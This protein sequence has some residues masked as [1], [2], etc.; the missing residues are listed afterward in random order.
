M[1]YRSLTYT[2]RELAERACCSLVGDGNIHISDLTSLDHP[3]AGAVTFIKTDSEDVVAKHLSTLRAPAA[4]IL[5][6]KVAPSSAPEGIAV[7]VAEDSFATFVG[8]VPLFYQEVSYPAG[9]HPTAVIDPSAHVDPSAS[10]GAYCVVGARS[11]IG[12]NVSLLPH[13]RVYED[14]TIHD[15]ARLYSG[16][17]I[18]SG[19]S[20][21]ARTVIHDNAV[22]GADGFGYL[23]DATCGLKKVPQVGHVEISSDVEIG[24][25]TCIDRGAYGPTR[26][27]RGVKID[28][29]VQ[30]GHNVT[31]GDF[32]VVCGHAA[33]GG[34]TKIG[35]GV[36]IGGCTGLADHLEIVSGVRVGGGSAV[37]NSL[38]EPGDYIG[39]PAVKAAQW[40]RIQVKLRREISGGQKN[41]K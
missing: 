29:L 4:V 23:P 28:N 34:S 37:I 8:L 18:R 38:L 11:S 36:V 15:G 20:I 14:V 24:A 30:I 21:G 25:N 33:I 26:I 32:T 40:R 41:K 13:V 22:I 39:Y 27:G 5:P 6:K 19:T 31:I 17:S 10:I 7:L 3:K 1:H 12:K 9:I 2:A 35:Q 16:V